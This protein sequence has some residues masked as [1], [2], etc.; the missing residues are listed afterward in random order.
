MTQALLENEAR[1]RILVFLLVLLIMAIWEIA[2]PRRRRDIPRLLRWSNNLAIVVLDAALVRLLFPVVAVGLAVIAQQNGWGLLN[3]LALPQWLAVVVSLLLFDLAIYLQHVVFHAVPALW[4][5]HRMHHADLEFDVT[6]GL[7][8]HPVEIILSMAVKMTLVLILGPPA[9]AVLLFEVVLNA[10]A[11]FNHANVDLPNRLDRMLRLVL[12]TPDMH[13]VH[14]SD[15]PAE[16]HS[17][18]GFNLPW[19]D[20]IFGTYTAQPRKGHT[21]MTI[22]L[23]QFRT[24]RDLWLDRMLM[25]PLRGD[26]ETPRRE[27]SPPSGG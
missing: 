27:S 16:T 26:E 21:G 25:Q 9:I 19:W 8:F 4:R 20:R 5:L 22:G 18:F 24:R 13:R 17:N 12:V 3:L 2:S 15:I 6:T 23:P 14:H 7:R 10:S 1:L 11:M